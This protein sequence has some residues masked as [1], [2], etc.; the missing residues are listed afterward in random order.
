MNQK[1]HKGGVK[2]QSITRNTGTVVNQLVLE[3]VCYG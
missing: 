1:I 3:L 2:T